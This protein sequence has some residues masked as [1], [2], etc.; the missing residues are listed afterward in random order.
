MLGHNTSYSHIFN[1]RIRFRQECL[2]QANKCHLSLSIFAFLRQFISERPYVNF[3]APLRRLD[4]TQQER[5]L[6]GR[7]DHGIRITWPAQRSCCQQT[8]V[9]MDSSESLSSNSVVRR[10]SL[11]EARQMVL[12]H[13]R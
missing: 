7:R 11:R 2:S 8:Y 10:R 4:R 12:I 5:I 3:G 13:R 9:S 1:E 6:R